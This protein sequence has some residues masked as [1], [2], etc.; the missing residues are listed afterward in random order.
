MKLASPF[1]LS[2]HLLMA[3]ASMII[4]FTMFF[5]LLALEWMGTAA[6]IF[7]LLLIALAFRCWKKRIFFNCLE[8]VPASGNV[9][10]LFLSASSL[11]ERKG[12]S[13]IIRSGIGGKTSSKGETSSWYDWGLG[14]CLSGRNC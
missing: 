1:Y 11:E 4:D 9:D 5:I 2:T 8:S 13:G 10:T 7:P 12:G 3:I 6:W 14:L